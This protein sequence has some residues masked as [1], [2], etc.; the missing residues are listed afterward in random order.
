M[1]SLVI[2]SS[3]TG[4]TKKVAESIAKELDCKIIN[5][6]KYCI[7]DIDLTDID[8]VFLGSGV[9]AN[10]LHENVMRFAESLNP[11]RKIKFA[12]FITWFGRGK[13]GKLAVEK[14][15]DILLKNNQEV[16]E[17]YFNCYGE[18]FVF[19]RKGHP[20]ESD[21]E[22]AKNWAKDAFVASNLKN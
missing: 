2:Y 3:K 5:L 6:D 4:N 21:L 15:K 7:N 20:N 1:N 17:D 13:S 18:G 8:F 11:S 22:K 19:F 9:Y 12:F 14:C 10:R 16:C